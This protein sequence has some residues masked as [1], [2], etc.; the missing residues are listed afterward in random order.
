[1]IWTFAWR[2]GFRV[3]IGVWGLGSRDFAC[4]RPRVS[5]YSAASGMGFVR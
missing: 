5:G 4:Q 2:V 3:Y 1:M